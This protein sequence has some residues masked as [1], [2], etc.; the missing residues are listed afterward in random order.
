VDTSG[1]IYVA[2]TFN[3][4]VEK[5]DAAG[6]FVLMFGKEVDKTTKA[7]VCTAA[8]GDACQVGAESV[9]GE[10]GFAQPVY[11][12]VD[13]SASGSHGD[14][15]VADSTTQSVYKFTN[16]GKF[17]AKINASFAH[18]EGAAVDG[19]GDLWTYDQTG[20]MSEYSPEGAFDQSWSSAL[21][22]PQS[23]FQGIA[24]D[25]GKNLY[26][27]RG[28]PVV[29][30]FS[31]SGSDLGGLL[32]DEAQPTGLA[33]D[34][35]TNDLYVNAG[36][37]VE[38]YSSKAA[39]CQPQSKPCVPTDTF[40]S[41]HLGDSV[42]LAVDEATNAVFSSN[43]AVDTVDRF[44]AGLEATTGSAED[45]ETHSGVLTGVVNPEGSEVTECFF[46]Y[47]E[48]E[49]YGAVVPCETSAGAGSAPVAVEAHLTGLR[50][51]AVTH[52]RV[53]ARNGA[54]TLHGDDVTFET[55]PVPGITDLTARNLTASTADLTA[56]VT[57]R[58][59]S[60]A[61][62]FELDGHAFATGS[63][64]GGV[65]SAQL[66]QHLTGLVPNTTYHWRLVASNTNGVTESSDQEFVYET[67]GHLLPDGRQYEMVTPVQKNGA[68]IGDLEIGLAP[69][70]AETGERLLV[71][72]IQGFAETQGGNG[73]RQTEGE[74]YA[75][76]R[77]PAGWL[78]TA[79]APPATTYESN[80]PFAQDAD[81][82][83]TLYSMPSPPGL[84]DDFYKRS[85][86]GELSDI[87]PA[88]PPEDGPKGT[89][90]FG[91][92]GVTGTA[93]M[94][95]ILWINGNSRFSFDETTGDTTYE[96]VGTGNQEPILVGVSG[97]SGSHS[98]ISKC[99]TA[100]GGTGSFAT[101]F[102]NSLSEDGS[103]VFFTAL[104]C[105]TGTGEDAG[106]PVPANELYARIG[107]S[108][109]VA[110]SAKATG[111]CTTPE[112][113]AS[114]TRA[115]EYEG[116]GQNG[117]R[118]Y[119]TSTQRLTNEATEDPLGT[120]TASHELGGCERT[121]G[122][123]GCNLYLY[124]FTEPAPHRLVDVSAGD[125]SG[126]GARVR[127]VVALSADGSHV[128][129]VARGVLSN[130]TNGFGAKAL[131]GQDN[132]YV[133][134]RA[135]GA[136]SGNLTFIATLPGSDE[137]TLWQRGVGSANVTPDGRYLVFPSTGT[138]TP[139]DTREDGAA[140]IF[141]YDDHDHTLVRISIGQNG[142]DDAGND[143]G[144]DAHIVEVSQGDRGIGPVRT[145]PTMS[146]DG[147]YIFF[148]SPI[149]LVAGALNDVVVD[150][151]GDYAQNI[152]EYHGGHVYLLSDGKDISAGGNFVGG[153][154]AG[155]SSVRLIGADAAG[156]NVIFTTA[157]KL[158][159]TRDTDTQIDYYDAR[160]CG[161]EGCM[162][163]AAAST[164]PCEDETTCH[165]S[166][167]AA[168]PTV[169]P[170]SLS[171]VGAGN[172]T[173]ATVIVAA[174]AKTTKLSRALQACRRFHRL[175]R[176]RRCEAT[177]HRKF[178]KAKRSERRGARKARK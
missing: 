8:S 98:L 86:S 177:A 70:L 93:D 89:D 60:T 42:G 11:V 69:V 49:G 134:E 155:R 171:Y 164:R 50:G 105:A 132:L 124:D 152:Y 54:G 172:A 3:F 64:S 149:A 118:A 94:S 29:E 111:D 35:Q 174:K 90:P 167:A 2:D 110:L 4:R 68:L 26:V 83:Y 113:E 52:Y 127:G 76:T 40:G 160:I 101:T 75:F 157:D 165:G 128:Y 28:I 161:S 163:P 67:S 19:E 145:D 71:D 99:G 24:V 102:Y 117:K 30:V 7:D 56:V 33:F 23:L 46:E 156:R 142:F 84:Q 37:K 159:P 17:L 140:Q 36:E 55:L 9:A 66:T 121:T 138:L 88:S 141:K 79:Q 147:E 82:G 10:G 6:H 109:T 61:F 87:G 81:T 178:G 44:V 31:E 65:P 137:G 158:D 103:V 15:Y 107:Q 133:Y 53:V 125:S 170:V 115:A 144:G 22:T 92:S 25:G 173:S 85:P 131:N 20:M 154:A 47:G 108:E 80:S 136:A 168:P 129:F 106:R 112:C 122:P 34:R 120:D 45:V 116:A 38:R 32:E 48:T 100:R 150:S 139:D 153:I 176:K 41:G 166:P 39:S 57:T 175:A 58:G 151:E 119:F 16:D 5:F 146:H 96:Y 62:H 78:A 135:P 143:G 114:P 21:A 12:A 27:E 77:T 43:D 14:V 95:H 72:S 18:I 104:P 13:D 97:G 51:G 130:A 1:N 148:Q 74:P 162:L 73:D 63:V 126:Q 169:V 59:L 123:Y 91:A